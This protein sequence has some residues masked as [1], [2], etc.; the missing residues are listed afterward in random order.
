[1]WNLYS[2]LDRPFILLYSKIVRIRLLYILVYLFFSPFSNVIR[3]QRIPL[4]SL[5]PI[6]R[7][8]LL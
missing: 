8:L 7:K 3:K 2:N 4:T 5:V 6:L 1:M